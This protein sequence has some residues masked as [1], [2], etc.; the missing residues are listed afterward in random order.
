MLITHQ[1]VH[2]R[3]DTIAKTHPGFP[4]MTRYTKCGLTV[5]SFVYLLIFFA[6][7]DDLNVAVTRIYLVLPWPHPQ[8]FNLRK[9]V[10]IKY[11]VNIFK[12]RAN[13]FIDRLRHCDSMHDLWQY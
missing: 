3:V 4:K 9:I 10:G 2:G 1:H 6:N 11:Y 12:F 8:M 13:P 5:F 7:I